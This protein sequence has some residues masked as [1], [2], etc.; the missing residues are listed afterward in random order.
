MKGIKRK[1]SP[2]PNDAAFREII[3]VEQKETNSARNY[4]HG[5]NVIK[6][7]YKGAEIK[8]KINCIYFEYWIFL[9]NYNKFSS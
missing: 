7:W 3:K 5:L 1:C 9:L 4:I 6:V 8:G 2:P